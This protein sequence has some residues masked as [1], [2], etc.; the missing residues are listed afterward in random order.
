MEN[1]I[2][3][4]FKV[5]MTIFAV[6][7]FG[8]TCGLITTVGAQ[9]A[10]DTVVIETENNKHYGF[11]PDGYII[12][13]GELVEFTGTYVLTGTANENIDFVGLDGEHTTYNVIVHNWDATAKEWYGLI[14]VSRNVTLNIT[15]Y[16][17]NNMLG[18]NHSGIVDSDDNKGEGQEPA[19]INITVMENSSLNVGAQYYD[20]KYAISPELNV[21]YNSEAACTGDW[22]TERQVTFSRGMP[23]KHTVTY[24]AVGD[25]CRCICDIEGCVTFDMAH[26]YS[27]LALDVEDADYLTKH[28][29]ACVNCKQI[30]EKYDHTLSAWEYKNENEHHIICAECDF[31]IIGEHNMNGTNT[32]VD[33]NE[34]YEVKLTQGEEITFFFRLESVYDLIINNSGSLILLRDVESAEHVSLYICSDVVVDLA[35]FK[36]LNTIINVHDSGSLK[37]IDS[38]EDK[39]G[40]WDGTIG[41]GSTVYG[42]MELDGI[43]I[44]QDGFHISKD[45]RL[46]LNNVT[47]DEFLEIVADGASYASLTNVVING[48]L[49]V[50]LYNNT[51]SNVKIYSGSFDEIAIWNTDVALF[52]NDLLPS[53]YAFANESGIIYGKRT[54]INNVTSVIEHAEHDTSIVQLDVDYH[55]FECS[56]G[57][58][59]ANQS[60]IPH[61][62][63]DGENVCAECGQDLVVMVDDGTSKVYSANIHSALERV[64]ELEGATMVLLRPAECTVEYTVNNNLTLDLNGYELA[65]SQRINVGKDG[66]L[67]ICDSSEEKTGLI[68]ISD[69][70]GV[71]SIDVSGKLTI[72][73]GTIEALLSIGGEGQESIAYLTVNDGILLGAS[74]AITL[75]ENYSVEINGGTFIDTANIF[76]SA[77]DEIKGSIVIKGGTFL[78]CNKFF[79]DDEAHP[80]DYLGSAQEC[81]KVFIDEEGNEFVFP[82]GDST[83]T[84]NLM[85]AHGEYTIKSNADV[86]YYYCS[87]CDVEYNREP[88]STFIYE[89]SE[90]DPS[91]HNVLCAVCSYVCYTE[92]H[93]GGEATC[94]R[95]A[96]CK[97]C[98]AEY[99]EL[100][101]KNHTGGEATCMEKAICTDC[102]QP[103]GEINSKNHTSGETKYEQ[104][105]DHP[106]MHVKVRV[107]CG[108][109]IEEGL[110]EDGILTCDKGAICSVC[111]LEYGD[112]PQGHKYD[113]ACD[114]DCNTCGSTRT[115][116]GHSFDNACDTECNE[117]GTAR[118]IAHTYGNDGKCV[119]CKSSNPA[120]VPQSEPK[121]DSLGTGAIVG[122]ILGTV[123]VFGGGAFA[124]IWF[125]LRKKFLIK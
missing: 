45:A 65:L 8:A 32:C 102:N 68:G 75:N 67:T 114:K 52:V 80:N 18:Y 94:V 60:L 16:G 34:S 81:Q 30:V 41:R 24:T 98:E 42:H 122:I 17:I 104:S 36:L 115:L 103:Y 90:D 86:H 72:E 119:I 37:I 27:I 118:T 76:D 124:V 22:T 43:K 44:Y 77:Y 69:D 125:V 78:N 38:D 53:G 59:E 15:V 79:I 71:T 107:C 92:S 84:S 20:H 49:Y 64:S 117:C 70:G 5:L 13:N 50:N 9:E 6:L 100:D 99:G 105:L 51:T 47:C 96:E 39:T 31:E 21:T 3:K 1:R 66:S 40:V 57:Y 7:L 109:I 26:E 54:K 106:D 12:G 55:W 93:T 28:A 97:Y 101:S 120:H 48:N 4:I 95:G 10:Q 85:V 35:G 123:A 63:E 113:N 61:I 112:K 87:I 108:E 82:Q 56:C 14:G 29:N 83:F 73:G 25:I 11:Y 116:N 110:H 19:S 74:V 111:K 89:L 46:T 33:C 62:A 23:A 2:T 88:H 91:M 121:N 58:A